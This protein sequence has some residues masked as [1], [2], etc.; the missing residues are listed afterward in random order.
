MR[1][2]CLVAA[3]LIELLHVVRRPPDRPLKQMIDLRLE[4]LIRRK[5]TLRC[6]KVYFQFGTNLRA[7]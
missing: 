7:G 4:D 5:P 6:L 1:A 3:A 2:A